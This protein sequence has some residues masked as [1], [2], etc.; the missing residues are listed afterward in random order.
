[1]FSIAAGTKIYEQDRSTRI[2]VVE[3]E[4]IIA[5]MLDDALSDFG[6]HV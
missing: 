6:Y 5:I 1:M 4:P 3:E 2:S